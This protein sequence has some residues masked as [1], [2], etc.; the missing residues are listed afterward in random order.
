MKA[1]VEFRSRKFPPY[2]GEGELINPEL[3]GK[4][5]VVNRLTRAIRDS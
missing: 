1:H 3:W 2:D 4:R 5:I